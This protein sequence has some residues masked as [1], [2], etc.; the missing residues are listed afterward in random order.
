MIIFINAEN[1]LDKTHY[2]LWLKKKEKDLK[3]SAEENFK[4]I[5]FKLM[6]YSVVRTERGVNLIGFG[7]LPEDGWGTCGC[8]GNWGLRLISYPL[9]PFPFPL[10]LFPSLFPDGQELSSFS[11]LHPSAVM[12]LPWSQ[13]IPNKAN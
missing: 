2:L 3:I 8:H 4:V 5:V 11:L 6:L 12:C 7:V 10:A 9:C 1:A 13:L